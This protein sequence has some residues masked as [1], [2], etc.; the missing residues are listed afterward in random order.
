MCVTEHID[1][2]TRHGEGH[3]LITTQDDVFALTGIT[4][5]NYPGYKE[6]LC[7]TSWDLEQ[8]WKQGLVVQWIQ[9]V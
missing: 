2:Q 8:H 1:F 3:A 4:S 9:L 6:P 5:S 7:S